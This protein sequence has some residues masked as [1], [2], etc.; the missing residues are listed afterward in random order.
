MCICTYMY[1]YIYT[2]I[3]IQIYILLK[4]IIKP[5]PSGRPPP[6]LRVPPRRNVSCGSVVMLLCVVLC[7]ALFSLCVCVCSLIVVIAS[8]LRSPA[9]LLVRLP[10][11]ANATLA[12]PPNH[13]HCRVCSLLPTALAVVGAPS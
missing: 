10:G 3:H 2:Y 8:V 6:L 13:E 9:D 12:S 4:M 5:G 1:I 7:V 11:L